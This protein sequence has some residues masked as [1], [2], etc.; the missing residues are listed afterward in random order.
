MAK[1]YAARPDLAEADALADGPDALDAF[2]PGLGS[3]YKTL[4]AVPPELF[5]PIIPFE[6]NLV[7]SATAMTRSEF[8]A[9]N[10][11]EAMRLREAILEDDDASASLIALAADQT[12]WT[13]LYLAGLEESGLLRPQA[14]APPIREHPRIVSLMATLSAGI[15][16]GPAGSEIVTSGGIADF[17]DQVRQWYGHDPDQLA[18]VDHIDEHGNRVPVM[19]SFEDYDLGL[20][21]PTHFEAFRVYVPWI[22]FEDRGAGLPAGFQIGGVGGGGGGEAAPLDFSAY[23]EGAAGTALASITGPLT[24]D[25]GGFV[26]TAQPLPYTVGF[27]NDPDASTQPGEIRIVT[28]LDDDLDARSLR[29][30]DMR[31]GDIS[32]HVPAGRGGRLR[33]PHRAYVRV[34]RTRRRQRGQPRA[35]ALRRRRHRRRIGRQPRRHADRGRDHAPELRHRARTG[36]GPVHEPAV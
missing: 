23:F 34:L 19:P 5:Y 21:R 7:A 22:P 6:F 25:T 24:V 8:I 2:Y 27:Q 4:G 11:A 35:A 14:D 26:P 30:G 17:F 15:L 10:T 12:E 31:I 18:D 3:L 16:A 29:L 20:S 13:Q 33:G 1:I 36:S 28:Q 9:Q 32:V